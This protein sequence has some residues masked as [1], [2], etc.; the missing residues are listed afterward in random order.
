MLLSLLSDQKAYFLHHEIHVKFLRI[1]EPNLLP[2][3]RKGKK[4]FK[5]NQ[6]A[7]LIHSL[8]HH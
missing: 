2:K 3:S 7:F 8:Q 1:L 4:T 6:E 5:T